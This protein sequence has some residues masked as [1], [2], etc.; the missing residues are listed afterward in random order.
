MEDLGRMS[1]DIDE[2]VLKI[3]LPGLSWD[4]GEIAQALRNIAD[5][6]DKGDTWGTIPRDGLIEGS[7]SLAWG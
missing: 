6:I 1:V 7:W 5:S 4:E 3:N 2:T